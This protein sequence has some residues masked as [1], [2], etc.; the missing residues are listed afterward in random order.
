MGAGW[1]ASSP[2]TSRGG[3][4]AT[5]HRRHRRRS[6]LAAVSLSIGSDVTRAGT[7]CRSCYRP[8]PQPP[9]RVLLITTPASSL[10]AQ[11]FSSLRTTA[12]LL[13]LPR[14]SSPSLCGSMQI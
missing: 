13:S 9:R 12:L 14:F 4:A 7:A 2:P 8:S 5:Q 6:A 1:R 3:L 10:L 11:H